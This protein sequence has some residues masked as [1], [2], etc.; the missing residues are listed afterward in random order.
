MRYVLTSFLFLTVFVGALLYFLPLKFVVEATSLKSKGIYYDRVVGT[1]WNGGMSDVHIA[2][3]ALGKV[4]V[5]LRPSSLV[6]LKPEFQF[7]F[8]GAVGTGRGKV[9]IGLDKSLTARDVFANLQL[10]AIK[11]LDM[12]LRRSP[13]KLNLTITNLHVN[14]DGNC[15]DANG[16]MTSDILTAVGRSWGW[17]GADIDGVVACEGDNFLLNLENKDGVDKLEAR[18][19]FRR[20]FSYEVQSRVTTMDSRL[21]NALISFGFQGQ[22]EQGLFLYTNV[23]EP[24][25]D[26]LPL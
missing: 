15:V 23:S 16:N 7:E 14:A 21:A 13:S 19:L 17:D 8:L 12:Q 11:H 10:H 3:E 18:A 25:A 5:S 1:I 2:G 20:D 9:V 6:L 24:R 22:T 4:G 26:N